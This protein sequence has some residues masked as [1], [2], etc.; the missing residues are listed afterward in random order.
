MT[1]DDG[2]DGGRA[3]TPS[4]DL[5]TNTGGSDGG[6]NLWNAANTGYDVWYGTTRARVSS[7]TQMAWGSSN[8]E[9]LQSS[10]SLTR[11]ISTC[12]W[13][14]FSC[15]LEIIN[16]R[17]NP[18][19][20]I[21]NGGAA[22][23][24]AVRAG[25]ARAVGYSSGLTAESVAY[26]VLFAWGAARAGSM[27]SARAQGSGANTAARGGVGPVRVFQAGEAAVRAVYDIGKKRTVVIGGRTRILDGLNA[28]AVSEMK[29]VRYQAYTQQ[30]R[31]SL[32]YAQEK[33]LRFDLYVRGGANPTTLSGPLEAAVR[34][35]DITLRAIP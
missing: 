34:S 14:E 17:V 1:I 31:D 7:I 25:D 12:G 22:T 35:G 10:I 18:F 21:L 8:L 30:L 33:G 32:A 29:N 9:R 23:I 4:T 26:T 15:R 5:G 6:T 28:E 11:E 13:T 19:S 3:R 16:D 27:Q 24:D 2:T 20:G